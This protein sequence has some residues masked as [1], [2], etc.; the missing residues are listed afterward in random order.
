M[1]LRNLKK[2]ANEANLPGIG[3]MDVALD[4]EKARERAVMA[5]RDNPPTKMTACACG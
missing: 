5:P 4:H 1:W 3:C 2:R